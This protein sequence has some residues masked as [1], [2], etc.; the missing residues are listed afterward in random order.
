MKVKLRW[1][2]NRLRAMSL[3]EIA[4]RGQ[5]ALKKK[6]WRRRTS[7]VA[8]KPNGI[9]KDIW[10]LSPLL[11]EATEER[12][13]LLDEADRYLTG[14]YTLLNISFEESKIDWHLDPQMGKR[15][16]LQFGLD[17]D[18]RN[19][20]SV[21]NVKNIWEKN[22][23]HHL[24]ILALAYALTG[25]KHYAKAVEEQLLSWV[26]QNPFPLGVNWTSSLEFGVRLISWVWIERLLRGTSSHKHL[27]GEGGALWSMIYWHQWL[28]TQHYSHGSS[29]NNHLIG[30]MAG[31][32]IATSVW[33]VFPES[34]Q[35]QSLAR[36]ILEREVS[37][38]TFPCGLNR[39][40][41]FSYQ[42]F[43]LE[44]FLLAGLEAEWLKAPFST[45]YQDWVRRM[46]EVIPL[47]V[48]VGG[49]LPQYGDG[50]DGMALQLRPLGSSRLDWLFR[51]GRQWL[52]AHVPLPSNNSGVLAATVIGSNAE[53]KVGE[54]KPVQG[55]IGF[56]DPGLFVL[57]SR[58]GE[59]D[60]VLCLADAGLLGYLSIAAHGHADALSFTLNVGGVPIIVDPGTYV[61]HADPQERAYFRSTKAHNTVVVDGVDQSEPAGT[62]LWTRQAQAKVLSWQGTPNGG[63]LVAEHEGYTRLPNQVIHRRRLALEGKRLEIIDELLSVAPGLNQGGVH[64]FQWR[65]HFSPLC[66]V[67]LKENFCQVSWQGGSL[68]IYL[69]NQLEWILAHGEQEA[70]WYSRGFNLKEATYTLSGSARTTTPMSLK[71]YLDL[72]DED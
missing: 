35:W 38:Q 51:L 57:A 63:V 44:F 68:G 58:R 25:N 8:P 71:N 49:N 15:A 36:K 3:Q 13:A 55:S 30:E 22:R 23:H 52:N 56:N 29:A 47:L 24:T 18:Y 64:D 61:Y 1:Y 37:Q 40:Q 50:D 5:L 16:P 62:F 39:E 42:I 65:L 72:S 10:K 66:Q 26:E 7:W 11:Q 21:G 28:I 17:L 45:N 33:P 32:F 60:E 27:F 12:Q 67:S 41:A 70:G 19:P 6:C 31:L 14:K 54:V 53:D 43:A 2:L 34:A 69:D 48:D 59:S 4:A 46:L 20:S 9:Q